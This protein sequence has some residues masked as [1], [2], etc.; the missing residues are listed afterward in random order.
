MGVPQL[1]GKDVIYGTPF[2]GLCVLFFLFFLYRGKRKRKPE[3]FCLPW[4][5]RA[6][7]TSIQRSGQKPPA[8]EKP[9]QNP[10]PAAS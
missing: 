6:Q 5:F 9:D 2:I 8:F 7:R 1:H 3:L 10:I 4:M